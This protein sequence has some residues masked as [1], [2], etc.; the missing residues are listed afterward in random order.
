M[1]GDAGHE[2]LQHRGG[3]VELLR[4]R[5]AALTTASTRT[6]ARLGVRFGRRPGQIDDSLP[7]VPAESPA[8]PAAAPAPR[9][10]R[11]DL[12][13]ISRSAVMQ[14]RVVAGGL[15]IEIV[16]ARPRRS[17]AAT[18]A[19]ARMTRL[20]R[21]YGFERRPPHAGPRALRPA[22]LSRAGRRGCRGISPRAFVVAH[23]GQRP[24]G[25]GAG[26]EIRRV[27]RAQTNHD[28]ARRRRCRRGRGGAPRRR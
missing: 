16:P 9:P 10:A 2:L 6:N 19:F 13:S 15:A 1:A 21:S 23:L 7:L 18:A 8:A 17:P 4:R 5:S 27:D 11:P 12:S 25:R 26:V 20:S 22:A 14:R 24:R 28:L 3:I